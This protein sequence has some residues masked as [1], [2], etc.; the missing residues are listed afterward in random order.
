[1]RCGRPTP[2]CLVSAPS[3]L[4]PASGLARHRDSGLVGDRICRIG[5]PDLR[6]S[7]LGGLGLARLRAP[8][9]DAPAWQRTGLARSA[10]AASDRAAAP[11]GG[12]LAWRRH[13]AAD[14]CSNASFAP[15]ATAGFRAVG[16]S[17][18]GIAR[19]RRLAV[20]LGATVAGRRHG[21]RAMGAIVMIAEIA[22]SARICVGRPSSA[23]RF[24]PGRFHRRQ[25]HRAGQAIAARA[26]VSRSSM[27]F[28]R[29][30]RAFGVAPS[31]APAPTPGRRPGLPPRIRLALGAGIGFRATR[32]LRRAERFVERAGRVLVAAPVTARRRDARMAP[33]MAACVTPSVIAPYPSSACRSLRVSCG[34][35]PRPV[36]SGRPHRRRWP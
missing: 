19:V 27:P 26:R 29:H 22:C 30:G 35:R 3:L 16:R 9:A 1:M 11:G 5:W 7:R 36:R 32:R 33:G 4:P 15:A 13:G 20:C 6:A 34:R 24:R 18:F 17:A 8:S 21:W 31:R 23:R 14:C 25:R 12:L 2:P 10:A 28:F